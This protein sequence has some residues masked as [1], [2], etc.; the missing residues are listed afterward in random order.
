VLVVEPDGAI[1]AELAAW[2]RGADY[3][4]V[5]ADSFAEARRLL[6]ER[7]PDAIV[8][9]LRLGAFNGLHLIF[10]ERATN[11]GVG[12]I[13]L[14]RGVDV[15][16]RAEAEQAGAQVVIKPVVAGDLLRAVAAAIAASC[17]SVPGPP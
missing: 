5:E 12:A 1:R 13:V 4:V 6:A 3:R 10:R 17:S 2:L 9:A 11:P 7:V 14:L 15:A 16:A 8:A